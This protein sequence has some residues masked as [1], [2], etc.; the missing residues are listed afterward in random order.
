MRTLSSSGLSLVPSNSRGWWSRAACGLLL[1]LGALTTGCGESPYAAD[2][3]FRPDKDGFSFANYGSGA[4]TTDLDAARMVELFGDK[5]CASKAGGKCRLTPPAE[6]WRERM[7]HLFSFG[8]CEGMAVLSSLFFAK[9][10]GLTPSQFGA[11]TASELQLAGNLMLET[12]IAKWGSTQILTP[13]R[14]GVFGT[15]NTPK[16]VIEKLRQLWSTGEYPTLRTTHLGRYDGHTFFPY[17]IVDKGGGTIGVMVYDPDYPKEERELT[18]DLN[19]EKWSYLS[20]IQPDG[21]PYIF[22]GNAT[23]SNLYIVTTGGRLGKQDCAFCADGAGSNAATAVGT[24]VSTT[25]FPNLQFK[26]SNQDEVLRMPMCDGSYYDYAGI[27]YVPPDVARLSSYPNMAKLL[28]SAGPPPFMNLPSQYDSTINLMHYDPLKDTATS[29]TLTGPGY[30][31]VVEDIVLH[32]GQKDSIFIPKGQGQMTYTTGADETPIVTVGFES[33]GADFEL[34]ILAD[35]KPTGLSVTVKKDE[36][37]GEFSFQIKNAQNY[38]LQ[39]I[40]IDDNGEQV[41]THDGET[42]SDNDTI[43]VKYG[44]WRGQGTPLMLHIDHDS[45]GTTDETI[46]ISDED[47]PQM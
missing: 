19:T 13:S 40:R 41:F 17:R 14:L 10:N 18:L 35:G 5:V 30:E 15:E 31:L 27:H 28:N 36:T 7:N 46:E 23:S 20:S 45:N 34:S 1:A 4:V 42:V 38:T 12:E 43:V 29:M 3:G 16:E 39:M 21:K 22:E 9:A 44:T 33:A 24:T 6:R 32:P 2:T 8:H 37:K 25:N 26:N 47:I 11:A